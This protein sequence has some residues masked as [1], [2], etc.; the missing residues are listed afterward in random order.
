[1]LIIMGLMECALA[2]PAMM[3]HGF[4]A[5]LVLSRVLHWQGIT[6]SSTVS[7]GRFLGTTLVMVLL[8]VG[9]GVLVYHFLRGQ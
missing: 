1:V 4:G 6:R 2:V 5:L 8:A 9:A 3:L 7:P